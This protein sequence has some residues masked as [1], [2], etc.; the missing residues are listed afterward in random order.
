MVPC[1]TENGEDEGDE[2]QEEALD[3]KVGPFGDV[4]VEA[5]RAA[6]PDELD[7]ASMQSDGAR[8]LPRWQSSGQGTANMRN[9]AVG[10]KANA[11]RLG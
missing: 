6:P 9:N 3:E 4:A 7:A 8:D 10:P 5:L 1:Q 11:G 2:E